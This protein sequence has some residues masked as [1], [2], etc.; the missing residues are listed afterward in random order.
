MFH[1]YIHDQQ[2]PISHDQQLDSSHCEAP[3]RH[4]TQSRAAVHIFAPSSTERGTRE[5]SC[6]HIYSLLLG[7]GLHK[8]PTQSWVTVT[9]ATML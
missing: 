7:T 5:L 6:L 8:T 3:V 4:D 9:Q 1:S 2:H